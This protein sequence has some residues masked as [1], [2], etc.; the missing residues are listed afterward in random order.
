MREGSFKWLMGTRDSFKEE[1]EEFSKSSSGD[2][3]WIPQLSPLANV[4]VRKCSRILEFSTSD[5]KEDFESVASESVKDPSHYARNLLEY[6]CFRALALSMQV[7]GYLADKKFRRLTFEMMLAWECPAASSQPLLTVDE[8]ATV[9]LEAFSRIAPAVPIISNVVIS[10]N[11]FQVLT[12]STGGRLQY[13]I[14]E[15]Y[16]IGLERAIKKL[17]NQSDSSLLSE[18]R[19]DRREKIVE[20]DGTVTTQPVLQ[21]LGIST[22]P[23]RLILTDHALYFEPLKV[24]S[25]DKA[26]RYDLA[27]DLKQSVKPELT[28]PWGTRL[29]DKAVAYKSVSLS[30]P[31]IMEFPE[32][33]GHSRRDYWLAI[34]QE[35]LFAHKFIRKYKL[36]GV[37]REEALL[38]AVLGILRLQAIQ[39][40]SSVGPIRC[41]ALLLFN[42]CDHLPG[43]DMIL[44]T[45]AN[46]STS[47]ELE[48]TNSPRRCGLHSSSALA[49]ATSLGFGFG[50]NDHSDHVLLVGEIAVGDTTPLEKV[51]NESRSSYEKV[52][53]AQETVNGVKV[54]GI[55]TNLAVMKELLFPVLELVKCFFSLAY[56]EEPLKSMVFCAIVAYAI[57]RGWLV[58]VLALPPIFIAIFMLLTLVFSQGRPVIELKVIAPPAKNAMEQ[59]LAVQNAVSQAEE[60]IQF[61][62]II[63]LKLRALLLSISPQ[64]SKKCAIGLSV[65]AMVLAF[66]PTKYIVLL[67]FIEA[68]TRYSPPR[69][70]S[71]ERWERRLREWWFSIP[72]APVALE[73]EKEDK[74]RR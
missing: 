13:S 53:L 33:K 25:Y 24:V 29:F 6:C 49:V 17:K 73:R 21:H 34:I 46:M 54:D 47:R 61:G 40:M 44:E 66:V 74:K 68:F 72:A 64:A 26:T 31:V 62:N 15:K 5:L 67:C 35:I 11:L 9:G 27:D 2:H 71:T 16:L 41:E 36:S 19:S 42:L 23:G 7:T 50:F 55:D 8:D 12:A 38:K 14:Y 18:L 1:M 70:A 22:W 37:G 30:E 58:Y 43:G 3:N 51:V 63:L 65:A 20:V 69:K 32:L 48:R 60:F 28:G 45:L 10:K 59:L 4:V 57:F 39:D 56:W 52:V